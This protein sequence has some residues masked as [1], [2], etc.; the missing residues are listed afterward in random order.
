MNED[1][2]DIKEIPVYDPVLIGIISKALP[3]LLAYDI[4]GVQPMTVPTGSI[5]AMRST[6]NAIERE[7]E[8]E[9]VEWM[10]QV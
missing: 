6:Y 10:E 1:P 4:C 3:N 8:A 5:F 9:L 2:T 7:V